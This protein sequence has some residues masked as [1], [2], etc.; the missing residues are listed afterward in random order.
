MKK[1]TYSL[2]LWF[3]LAA[4]LTT[5]SVYAQK[6]DEVL[7]S[8]LGA[9]QIAEG[10]KEA[11]KVGTENVVQIVSKLDGFYKSPDIKIFFPDKLKAAEKLLRTAGFGL[12]VEEFEL[13]MNRAAERSASE[14]KD[15]FWDAITQ[16][17]IQDA[18][19]ILKGKDNEATLYFQEK[20]SARLQEIF[21]P[22]VTTVMAEVGVTRLYQ[23]LETKVNTFVPLGL[24]TDF[25]LNQYVT[26]KALEGLFLKLSEEE[27]KIRND[28]KARITEL[29]Q[30]VF[31]KE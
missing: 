8:V 15:L 27:R 17:T 6:L 11:L 9:D 13:S 14:A 12:L 16:M 10:L 2:L 19:K 18:E 23:D 24:F 20:T 25:D 7:Q 29:L 30:K 1:Y 22:I 26:E 21:S 3:L 5:S 31:N 28:P 4:G